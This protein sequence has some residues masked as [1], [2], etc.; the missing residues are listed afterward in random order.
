LRA[1]LEK[2][3]NATVNM[4]K[5][6]ELRK[7]EDLILAIVPPEAGPESELWDVFLI[8]LKDAPIDNVL[9]SSSGYGEIDGEMRRT[10]TLRYFYEQ[11]GPLEVV[12]IEPIQSNLFDLTNEY[13]ISF[14]FE[15]Y[16]YDRRFLFVSGS[17]HPMHFSTI[18][19]I[20]RKGVMM[21]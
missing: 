13:W 19:F 12:P 18:P 4:K 20:D 21:R 16:M 10:T 7:V 3:P 17:I 5:D 9:I 11:I 2:A 8:N 1:F 6:I 14:N 15:E